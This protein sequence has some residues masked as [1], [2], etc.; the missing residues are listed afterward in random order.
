MK[1]TVSF[2][3]H[4]R[5]NAGIKSETLEAE[6]GQILGDFLEPLCKQRNVHRE[7]FGESDRVQDPINILINGRN[8]KFLQGMDTTLK[9]GDIISIFPP[10]GGG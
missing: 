4:L 7:V 9:D 2:F 6:D 3:G 5:A 1:L 10:T 8:I